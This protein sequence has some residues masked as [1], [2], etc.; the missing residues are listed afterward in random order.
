M[1]AVALVPLVGQQHFG[2]MAFF[3]FVSPS[4]TISLL[5]SV[6]IVVV[7]VVVALPFSRYYFY[8]CNC[9]S[10]YL[11]TYSFDVAK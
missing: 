11:F 8:C 4:L 2:A 9:F 3:A 6:H 5:L 7:V 1:A 10:V